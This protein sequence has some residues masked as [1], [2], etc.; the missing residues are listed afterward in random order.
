MTEELSDAEILEALREHDPAEYARIMADMDPERA[1]EEEVSLSGIRIHGD[2]TYG[3]LT[4][5]IL[6]EGK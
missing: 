3:D 1:V 4:L 6:K 2:L 5:D